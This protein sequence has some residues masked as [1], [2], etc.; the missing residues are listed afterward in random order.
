MSLFDRGEL[1]LYFR[2]IWSVVAPTSDLQPPSTYGDLVPGDLDEWDEYSLQI[3]ID[4]GRRQLDSLAAQFEQ[5]RSRGQYL[6]TL[7][8]AL[9]VTMAAGAARYNEYFA[10]FVIWFIGYL[11]LVVAVLG[12]AAIVAAPGQLGGIDAVLL[13]RTSAETDISRV[14][15]TAYSRAV[16][17]SADSVRVRH[18]LLRDSIWFLV[19]GLIVT[20]VGTAI[21][22]VTS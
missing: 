16:I 5:T 20:G 13:S 9:L 15:A 10:V 19:V 18:S 21:V 4:E 12:A 11:L 6:F 1:A 14:L 8:L 17:I 22:S 3:M 2:H 7:G